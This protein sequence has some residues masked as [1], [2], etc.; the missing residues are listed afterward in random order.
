MLTGPAAEGTSVARVST[1]VSPPSRDLPHSDRRLLWIKKRVL[2]RSYQS[3]DQVLA[4]SQSTADA[5]ESFYH[6]PKGHV[7]VLP[8]PT[9]IDRIDRSIPIDPPKW[10]PHHAHL[11]CVGRLSD[12]KGQ[13]DLI[14]AFAMAQS[15]L[16]RTSNSPQTLELHLLGEGPNESQLRELVRQQGLDQVVHFHGHVANPYSMMAACDLVCIPSHYEGFPNVMME[17]MVCR[18]PI[19]AT[20]ASASMEQLMSNTYGL[21][22]CQPRSIE[23][24]A[25]QIVDR[26]EHAERW[27]AGMEVARRYVEKHH[28]MNA[29]I[30]QMSR[31]L[32]SA[33]H[34]RRKSSA[35]R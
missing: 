35:S 25:Q 30:A 15:R 13:Q 32:E 19:V 27:N 29:W 5:A 10:N 4:V 22:L 3:A 6:L 7:Q 18:V 17:A 34:L 28:S 24:L 9:D 31:I 16:S 33:V 12:E 1:I 2:R 26:F 20:A 8:S 21:P 14:P 23:G 11:L